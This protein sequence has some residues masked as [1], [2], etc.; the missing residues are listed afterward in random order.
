M[1]E[2]SLNSL[3]AISAEG[4]IT[5]ANQAAVKLIG[6]PRDQ[7]I[8]TSFSDYFTDPA[9]AE[10]IY[11]VGRELKMIELKKEIENLK[12]LAPRHARSWSTAWCSFARRTRNSTRRNLTP[13]IQM[14]TISCIRRAYMTQSTAGRTKS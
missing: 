7:L 11:H 6:I 3:V 1:I 8:G 12:K 14:M 13:R 5:D 2:S 9:K 4:K 10:E